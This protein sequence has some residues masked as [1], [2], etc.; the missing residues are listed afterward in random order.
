ML[1]R[2]LAA[3]LPT[4]LGSVSLSL[5]S[6]VQCLGQERVSIQM[7]VFSHVS[8]TFLQPLPIFSFPSGEG[9]HPREVTLGADYSDTDNSLLLMSKN[10]EALKI[11]E[12][13]LC[14][15]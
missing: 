11:R 14:L 8:S 4:P 7:P 9:G 5:K 13:D 3:S 2:S 10:N 1:V 6:P 15:L 12:E